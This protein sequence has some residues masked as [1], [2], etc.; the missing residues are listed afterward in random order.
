M[1]MKIL[2]I[3]IASLILTFAF[4][5]ILWRMKDEKE[6]EASW[7]AVNEQREREGKPRWDGKK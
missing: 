2:I 3:A 4:D 7:K 5:Y 1:I 6:M